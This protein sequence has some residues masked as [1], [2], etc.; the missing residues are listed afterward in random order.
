MLRPNNFAAV[1]LLA[2]AMALVALP[3][4]ATLAV[5]AT[6]DE[7]VESSPA[8]IL[9]RCVKTESKFDPSNRWI[10]TYSTFR[11][12]KAFKGSPVQEITVVTPGGRVGDIHQDTIGMPAFA[13]G[14]ENVVFIKNSRLGPTV[15][16]ADQ[17][18]YSVM[19]GDGGRRLIGPVPTSA[20]RLDRQRGVAV[21]PESSRSLEDFET[22]VRT[23][24]R[25]SAVQRMELVEAQRRTA[26][27]TSFRSLLKQYGA[28][29]V[30]AALGLA[31][32]TWHLT[33]R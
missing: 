5:S 29:F 33:R 22:E 14:S 25:R 8:I 16:Y 27:T 28:I 1:A 12:E 10:L 24:M 13:E 6:F 21:A 31:L 2:S 30:L 17:G 4:D 9:G 32:A 19:R 7:K 18:A 20:V 15:S 26:E 11:V 3:A 23:S